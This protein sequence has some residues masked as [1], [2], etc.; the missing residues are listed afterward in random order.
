VLEQR[1]AEIMHH[2]DG[3][4]VAA[5]QP[6]GPTVKLL[7]Q[8]LFDDPQTNPT[9]WLASVAQRDRARP[10]ESLRRLMFF[11]LLQD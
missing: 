7:V 1:I 5:Q 4:E 3:Q 6:L 9:A 10:E 2:W 11:T 8:A